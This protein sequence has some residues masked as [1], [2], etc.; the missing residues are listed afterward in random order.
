MKYEEANQ[1]I[2]EY[3][4]KKKK[5]NLITVHNDH[6]KELNYEGITIEISIAKIYNVYHIGIDLYQISSKEH[7]IHVITEHIKGAVLDWILG[8]DTNE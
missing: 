7:L 8:D 3:F 4:K 6:L 2:E 5:L 1:I